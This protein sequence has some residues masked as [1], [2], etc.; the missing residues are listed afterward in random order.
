MSFFMVGNLNTEFVPDRLE[1]LGGLIPGDFVVSRKINGEVLSKFEDDTWDLTTYGTRSVYTFNTWQTGDFDQL[2]RV[3]TDEIKSITW[4]GMF[5]PRIARKKNKKMVSF[6][7]YIKALKAIAKIAYHCNVSIVDSHS[8]SKFQAALKSSFLFAISDETEQAQWLSPY[9]KEVLRVCHSTVNDDLCEK[10][11]KWKIVPDESYDDWVKRLNIANKY[12]RDKGKRTPLVPT[13]ILATILEE[14][15]KQLDDALPLMERF[16]EFFEAIY[17]DP[18]LFS[19]SIGRAR[20]AVTRIIGSGRP[21]PGPTSKSRLV[22]RKETLK[23][24]GL[25]GY[26]EKKGVDAHLQNITNHLCQLQAFSAILIHFYSG[27]RASE[28]EVL[29]FDCHQVIDIPNFGKVDV[30]LSHTKKLARSNFSRLL[31]WVTSPIA[32]KAIKASQAIARINWVR[33]SPDRF[34]SRHETVP[35]WLAN[36]WKKC[37]TPVSYEYP[38][39]YRS[40]VL[41]SSIKSF[42]NVEIRRSDIEELVVFDAFRDWDEEPE[43]EIGQPWP[44]STHQGRRSAAV[45]ASR[46]GMVSLPSLATQFK[47]LTL[48]M[49]AL[50]AEN[51]A[52]AESFIVNE[53]GR[54]PESHT[55]IG[56][57][58]ASKNLNDSVAFEEQVIKAHGPLLGG[59]GNAFQSEKDRNLPHF[60][61][62]ARAIQKEI[63]VG[64]RK[65]V[66]LPTGGGCMNETGPCDSYGIDWTFPCLGCAKSVFEDDVLEEAAASLEFSMQEMSPNSLSYKFSNEKLRLI[67]A[68]LTD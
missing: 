14:T 48:M 63:E 26:L 37:A 5:N 39:A 30:L 29:P 61:D 10:L 2:S 24:F 25:D 21:S 28:V 56:D 68:R 65:Y 54:I 1:D 38:I 27:M 16:V 36:Q 62:D 59:Q 44:L 57:L 6:S 17:E 35:L 3:I 20:N 58:R 12:I 53:D 42:K 60:L 64:K 9:I 52:F 33:N 46:S 50:Y 55:V 23:R 19:D 40:I 41:A 31:P 67:K 51:S 15:E 11:P 49:T 22:S 32:K 66:P 7:G 4:L 43:F 45:Y 8:N 34:P 18:H 13:R 47:H